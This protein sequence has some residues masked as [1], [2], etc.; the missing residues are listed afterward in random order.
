V[1]DLLLQS[2]ADFEA[3][4]KSGETTLGRFNSSH[5]LSLIIIPLGHFTSNQPGVYTRP[6]WI[7]LKFLY[8][9]YMQN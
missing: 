1:I 7:F 5:T 8:T 6:F 3:R 2:G 4:T 9:N